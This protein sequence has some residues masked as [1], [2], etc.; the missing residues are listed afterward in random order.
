MRRSFAASLG[1]YAGAVALGAFS[2]FPFLWMVITSVKGS[3]EIFTR[4]PVFVPHSPTLGRYA[5]VLGGEFA[6]ALLNSVIVATGT[7]VLGVSVAVLAG[8]SL[9]RFRLPLRRYLLMLILSTQMF[10]LVALIIPLFIVMRTLGLL[11]TYPGLILAYLSFTVPLAAWMMRGFFQSIPP[12]LEDA[13]MVDGATRMG[14]FLRVVL[15]V[16][17]PG[18]AATSIYAFIVAWNEFLIA[19]TFISDEQ[20]RTLPVALQSFIGRESTDWGAIMAASVIFTLPVIAFFLLVHK[21]LTRGMAAGAL[22]G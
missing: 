18:V 7:T 10:P 20:M 2:V 8:Y 5:Q 17:G 1:L 15:P 11:N 4:T 22:K 14:A 16:A 19:L 6:R 13:A 3:Q 9:A 12:E 21:R